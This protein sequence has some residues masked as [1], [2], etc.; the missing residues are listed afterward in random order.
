MEM[1]LTPLKPTPSTSL[2]EHDRKQA[3]YGTGRQSWGALGAGD[4]VE[5]TNGFS[6]FA[7]E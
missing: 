2:Q 6:K 1:S 5:T 3:V 4:F 7:F